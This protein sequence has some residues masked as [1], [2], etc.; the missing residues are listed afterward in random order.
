MYKIKTITQFAVIIIITTFTILNAQGFN[1][2]GGTSATYLKI[3]IDARAE[4]MG[5]AVSAFINDASATFYNPAGLMEIDNYS[6]A[7]GH[8]MLPADVG[9]SY[10]ALAKRWDD[11]NSIGISAIA[12]RTDD[13]IMRTILQPLG[14]G[15][16][17]TFAEYAFGLHYAHNFTPDLSVG[18][19]FRMLNSIPASGLYSEISWAADMGLQY[20]T[21]LEGMLK[22]L[23]ISVVVSNF[24]PAIT[25]A[26]ES[27]GIPLKYTVGISKLHTFN[28]NNSI[29]FGANW[30]K[31]IDQAQ[32]GQI[33]F[34]Y[35]YSNFLFL[36]GGY[37][38]KSDSETY[39]FGLGIAQ[40]ISIAKVQ[41]DY[42]YSDFS[43]LTMIHRISAKFVF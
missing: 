11:N 35:N 25:Y 17:F 1:K 10:V 24:G 21:G 34:E 7:F 4:G 26:K 32:R 9:L 36:R 33:G 39:S 19:S 13:M 29:M 22:N 16:K 30:I 20:H 18:F 31:A 14:T 2:P 12:L 43:E 40:N 15:Q 5:E 8:T 38:I 23:N 41:I 28:K 3:G 6:L 27:Y 42:S 37:K